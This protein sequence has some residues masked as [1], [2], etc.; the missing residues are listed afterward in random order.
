MACESGFCKG[1]DE[2]TCG[3]LPSAACTALAAAAVVG[4]A[5]WLEAYRKDKSE[6]NAAALR[7]AL[8]PG[9]GGALQAFWR[10]YQK[11]KTRPDDVPHGLRC[12]RRGRE[13]A[14]LPHCVLGVQ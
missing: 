6:A 14:S 10:E 1:L 12:R 13:D 4:I 11:Y 2:T 7:E 8:W 3:P 5:G 9:D